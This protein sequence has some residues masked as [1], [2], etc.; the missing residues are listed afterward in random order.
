MSFE[1]GVGLGVTYWDGGG[2]FGGVERW[3]GGGFKNEAPW[4]LGA[5]AMAGGGCVGV[6]LGVCVAVGVCICVCV[7]VQQ[8]REG[9][10]EVPSGASSLSARSSLSLSIV[11]SL[12]RTLSLYSFLSLQFSIAAK[13][14]VRGNISKCMVCVGGWV[15]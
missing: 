5:S 14:C 10:G 4:E 2:S 7:S 13:C 15:R 12:S 6:C 3:W 8:R 1:L 11:L 9:E